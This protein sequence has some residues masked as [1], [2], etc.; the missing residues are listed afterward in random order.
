MVWVMASSAVAQSVHPPD[1]S[2]VIGN[3][4]PD[5]TLTDDTG[6]EFTLSSLGDLPIVVFTAYS[7]LS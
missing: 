2:K 4:L 1:E 7:L 6:K 3:I 5:V